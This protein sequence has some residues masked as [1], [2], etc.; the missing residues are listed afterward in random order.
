MTGPERIRVHLTSHI[1]DA[2]LAGA[3]PSP[4]GAPQAAAPPASRRAGTSAVDEHVDGTLLAEIDGGDQPVLVAPQRLSTILRDVTDEEEWTG[5]ASAPHAP[6]HVVALAH[7]ADPS[8]GSGGS[9]GETCG[10]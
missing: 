10:T 5:Q 4:L 2:E 1:D 9:H 8:S 7:A 6:D 3:L